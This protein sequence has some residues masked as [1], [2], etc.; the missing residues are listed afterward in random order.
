MKAVRFDSVH[1]GDRLGPLTKLVT[2]AQ[3]RAY[4]EASGD[5][6]PIHLD[7]SAARARGL[8]GTVAHG[9]L[10]MAFLGQ[11]LT[12]WVG[13]NG[14]VASFKA[15]FLAMVYPGDIISCYGEVQGKDEGSRSADIDLWA[16][17]QQGTKVIR[18][19]ATVHFQA[20]N[21]TRGDV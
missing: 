11:V 12:N 5:A 19:R 2:D 16:E 14:F 6:N 3:I 17:N 18:G 9:M 21:R 20:L 10:G 15:K 4:A 13:C 7:A 1:V 8:Q